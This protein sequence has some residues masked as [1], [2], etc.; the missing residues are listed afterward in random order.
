MVVL[1]VLALVVVEGEDMLGGTVDAVVVDVGVVLEEVD[2]IVPFVVV[3]LVVLGVVVDVV[4]AV[5]FIVVI[6]RDAVVLDVVEL[7]VEGNTAT[8]LPVVPPV[9]AVGGKI[10]SEEKIKRSIIRSDRYIPS[11]IM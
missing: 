5:V 1:V 10:G 2:G 8:L 9:E 6:C 3:L 11:Y 4:L 7:A